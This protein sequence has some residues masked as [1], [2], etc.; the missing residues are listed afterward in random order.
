MSKIS[1]AY[2]A[3]VTRVQT[4]LSTHTRI[5]NPYKVDENPKVLLV[6]GWGLAILEGSAVNQQISC[7]LDYRRTFQ[8]VLTRQFYSLESDSSS[9]VTTEKNLMEDAFL[10]MEDFGADPDLGTTSVS[11]FKFVGD[12][13]IEYIFN[14]TDKFLK[15]S[16]NYEARIIENLN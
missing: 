11:T 12:N 10:V 2:D 15:I 8:V 6:K 5:T 1:D 9:K 7:H 4:V 13:G 3:I 16:L 14:E